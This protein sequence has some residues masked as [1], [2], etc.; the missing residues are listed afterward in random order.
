MPNIGSTIRVINKA[1][2]EGLKAAHDAN[3]P[4]HFAAGGYKVLCVHCRG[5]QFSENLAGLGIVVNNLSE[6]RFLV[7]T[8]CSHVMMF[9]SK[10]Q[11]LRPA[12]KKPPGEENEEG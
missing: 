12:A 4:G 11:R 10:V 8:N 9:G 7:C 3:P 2:K 6:A 5:E 1:V